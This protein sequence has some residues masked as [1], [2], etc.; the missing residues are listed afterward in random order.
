MRARACFSVLLF[1]CFLV[2]QGCAA[3]RV[4]Q[5][6]PRS[7]LSLP[8]SEIPVYGVGAKEPAFEYLKDALSP[9]PAP[10]RNS[11]VLFSIQDGNPSGHF[12]NEPA[13]CHSHSRKICIL[14]NQFGNYVNALD[15]VWHETAH[16][17]FHTPPSSATDEW[18]E[19]AGPV[20]GRPYDPLMDF[21]KDFAKD[22]CLTLYSLTEYGE[23]IAE[24][25]RVS[26]GYVFLYKKHGFS[27]A[28]DFR[29]EF[30]KDD[31]YIRKLKY[32]LKWGFITQEMYDVISPL[33]Q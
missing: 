27:G 32:L 7:I 16:A 31:R 6:E 13:H 29:G 2:I 12:E 9:M 26:Y 4:P 21:F 19:I 33:L 25:T 8:H 23:D 24:F 22:G 20:Y 5:P 30:K 11:V 1:S 14:K 17:Y 18:K 3:L 10:V 28:N 15:C